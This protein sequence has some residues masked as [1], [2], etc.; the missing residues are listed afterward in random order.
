MLYT[1][2]YMFEHVCWCCC[3]TYHLWN[4]IGM[5]PVSRFEVLANV[6]KVSTCLRD[7]DLPSNE[8]GHEGAQATGRLCLAATDMCD[9][10]LRV[11]LAWCLPFT[12]GAHLHTPTPTCSLRWSDVCDLWV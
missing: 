3:D 10:A 11:V 4:D 2:Y 1:I 7:I 8:I 12:A 5:P 6:L 9:A